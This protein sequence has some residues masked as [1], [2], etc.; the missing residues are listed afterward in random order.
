MGWRPRK[1]PQGFEEVQV[2]RLD[3]LRWEVTGGG[4]TVG[5]VH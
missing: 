2:I 5:V 1:G 3:G 4:I